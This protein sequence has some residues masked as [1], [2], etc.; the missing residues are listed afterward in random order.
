MLRT[1]F[2]GSFPFD[3]RVDGLRFALL[4]LHWKRYHFS[5]VT[6][7][8]RMPD[9]TAGGFGDQYFDAFHGVGIF[10]PR[11]QAMRAVFARHDI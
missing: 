2:I 4:Y 1:F 8:K 10:K 3:I 9:A 7:F 6:P 11:R 5:D